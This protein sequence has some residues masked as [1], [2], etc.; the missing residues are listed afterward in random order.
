MF[1]HLF[2]Y[3]LK[4]LLRTKEMIFW[5]LAFPII[6]SIFFN[7]AFQNL[8]SSEGF[9]PIPAAVVTDD[10]YAHHPFLK[11]VLKEVSEGEDP[12]LILSEVPLDEAK[13]LLEEGKIRGYIT[14]ENPI[15]LHVKS[16]GF[17]QNILRLFLDNVNQ[18]FAVVEDVTAQDPAALEAVFSAMEEERDFT[19]EKEKT[20]AP[21]S[22]VLNYFYSLIAMAC[23]YGAFFGADEVTDIQANI[24]DRAARIN[25]APV[26]KLKDF[27]ASSTASYVV[28]MV[29][30]SILLL[31][32]RFVLGIE[33]GD[34]VLLLVLTTFVGTMTGISFGA[35]VSSLVKKG[36]NLKVAIIITV[37]MTGSFLA[38]MMYAQMKYIVYDKAPILAYIN[39]VNLITD[40]FYSLYYFEDLG[41][42]VMNI[43]ILLVMTIVFSLGTYMVLRRRKYASI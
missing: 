42:Y 7:L 36:E 19:R 20:T 43:L 11:D 15:R 23:M 29:N 14:A 13:A 40:S 35:F 38:G 30:M 27:L 12:L 33:F 16:S 32:L 6:L 3:R 28:L 22:Q 41:R 1:G 5:T 39:P 8:D 25:V 17:S 21:P 34:R 37:S 26:H 31:F 9:D 4:K 24:S 18:R 2:K 10:S